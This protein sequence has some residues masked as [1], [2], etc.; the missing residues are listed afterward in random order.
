[1]RHLGLLL[2][3]TRATGLALTVLI[4]AVRFVGAVVGLTALVAIQPTA[5]MDG[6]NATFA[7]GHVGP[8]SRAR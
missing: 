8:R 4:V 6:G 1:M 3:D 2:G 5:G 7:S